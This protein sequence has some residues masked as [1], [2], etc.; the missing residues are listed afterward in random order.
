MKILF[1]PLCIHKPDPFSGSVKIQSLLLGWWGWGKVLTHR[2]SPTSKPAH[3]QEP[4]W[5]LQ[6]RAGNLPRP[7]GP[8]WYFST[9]CFL[10]CLGGVKMKIWIYFPKP[11]HSFG[12]RVGKAKLW[13]CLYCAS[14]ESSVVLVFFSLFLHHCLI[15]LCEMSQ[16]SQHCGLE[17]VIYS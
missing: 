3:E 11:Q 17:S 15:T 4:S 13:F 14:T 16:T 12:A 1:C 6:K 7:G 5:A 8:L 9:S 2:H 10:S